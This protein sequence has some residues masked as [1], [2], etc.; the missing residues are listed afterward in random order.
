[1]ATASI[2]RIS[3]TA[4]EIHDNIARVIVGKSDVVELALVAI[5]C[6]GHILIEDVPGIGKTMLARSIAR[7]LGCSFNRI[8]CTPDLLP[9]DVTGTYI[10]NQK[11]N[12]FEFRSGPVFAQVLL[13][14]RDQQGDAPHPIG[15]PGGDGG[16]SDYG[17]GRNAAPPSPLPCAGNP[18]PR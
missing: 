3:S 7:S 11:T 10:Y 15:L 2:E 17:G 14:E 4:R 5:L 6:E 1:M 8:Q 16:A 9:S 12:D 18:E 13:A